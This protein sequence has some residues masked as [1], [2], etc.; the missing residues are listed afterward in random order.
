VLEGTH[1]LIIANGKAY[2]VRGAALAPSAVVAEYAWAYTPQG[3]RNITCP[4]RIFVSVRQ[5]IAYADCQPFV[6]G[7]LWGYSG[8]TKANGSIY[9]KIV[10][11]Y[12][13]DVPN[14]ATGCRNNVQIYVGSAR[15]WNCSSTSP[16][17]VAVLYDLANGK[18]LPAG[19]L[20][21]IQCPVKVNATRVDKYT[22]TWTYCSG[23]QCQNGY[24]NYLNVN[25]LSFR[26]DGFIAEYGITMDTDIGQKVTV[27]VGDLW[28]RDRHQ[29]ADIVELSLCGYA[30][31]R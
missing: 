5:G 18:F 22:H 17:T 25:G 10:V 7:T 3:P 19:T 2:L 4:D 13:H 26:G 11:R 21:N 8:Y 23:S 14:Y 15:H 6:P 12:Y 20:A 16:Y 31:V 28:Y 9:L 24:V 30:R 27:I 1:S 29:G